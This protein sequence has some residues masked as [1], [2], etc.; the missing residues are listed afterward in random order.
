MA[1]KNIE[2]FS[3]ADCSTLTLRKLAE[4]AASDYLLLYLGGG[5]IHLRENAVIRFL[6][7]ARDTGADMVYSDYYDVL[8]SDHDSADHRS[9][10]SLTPHPLIDCQEG[11]LRDDFDFGKVLFFKTSALR[12]AIAEMTA[13]Y[14][15]AGL[16]DLRL[17]LGNIVHIPEPLYTFDPQPL[18]NKEDNNGLPA[19]KQGSDDG[20]REAGE[21]QFDYVNPKNHE[22]QIEMEAACT[23]HLKRI[24]AY[25]QPFDYSGHTYCD[26]DGIGHN[27]SGGDST[28]EPSVADA[29]PVTASVVIPVYNRVKTIGDAVRCALA[30][31]CDFPYNVI[32]IDNHSTDGTSELL[33][34]LKNK[35][36]EIITPTER[37]LGIGGCWNLAV[38]SPLCGEFAVQLDSDDLYSGPDTLQKIVTALRDQDCAMLVGSYLLTDFDLNPIPPGLIDHRE[39]TEGNGRNNALR[40]NG[41]GAPRAFRT[42]ILRKIGGFPNVSY[43]E[44]YAVGLRIGREYKIGRLYEPIYYCRRWGG[45][46]DSNLPLAKVNANNSYKDR[47]RTI[48]LRARIRMNGSNPDLQGDDPDPHQENPLEKHK[49]PNGTNL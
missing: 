48:E 20:K 34:E 22:V 18:E 23:E 36:L 9:A 30:Q 11:A 33:A 28:A 24:G 8:P 4:A 44:D 46:S 21:R 2:S 42:A 10:S 3:L 19:T 26:L 35:N 17:R 25:L 27:L 6:N 49:T 37:G 5:T 39:W 7:I 29:W 41:L 32:V 40:V 38:N 47:L 45:N 31:T 14:K 15:Y 43:G 1:E 13:D 12:E 16:Y